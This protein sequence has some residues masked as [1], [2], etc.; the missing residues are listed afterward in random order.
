MHVILF[1]AKEF[2]HMAKVCPTAWIGY[3]PP[4][5]IYMV[6]IGVWE[7]F[8]VGGLFIS[9]LRKTAYGILAVNMVGAVYTHIAIGD[10]KGALLPLFLLGACS[11]L[12]SR[13][14]NQPVK[15]KTN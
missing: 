15:V 10:Y 8:C 5:Y 2:E 14:S 1:Q 4:S 3:T 11:L 12:F 6:T 9:A 7:L 13:S